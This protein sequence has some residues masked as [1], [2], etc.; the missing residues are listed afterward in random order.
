MRS[1]LA[2]IKQ[3]LRKAIIGTSIAVLVLTCAVF[4]TTEYVVSGKSLT[5]MMI[6]R[7]AM[8]AAN[9]TAALAFQNKADATEVLSS[10]RKDANTVAACLYDTNGHVFAKYPANASDE[11]FP[12]SPQ[13]EGHWFEKD[14]FVIFEPIVQD[15]RMLGT[16]YMKT[17]LGELN[18][19]FQIYAIV[20]I[21][22]VV[23]SLF[24]S[25]GLSNRFQKGISAPIRD[26][27]DTARR[28]SELKIIHCGLKN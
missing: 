21:V 1:K 7:A 2:S 8:I 23:G 6:T 16:V 9:S 22:I 18:E 14:H 5:R 10:L 13:K 26:L 27:A 11:M 24:A 17:D 3:K 20:L 15:N 19:K 28:I 25:Y 4:L 12:A